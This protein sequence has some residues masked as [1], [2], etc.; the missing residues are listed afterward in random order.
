MT[1]AQAA[2][3]AAATSCVEG[4]TTAGIIED[5]VEYKTWLDEQDKKDMQPPPSATP[6]NSIM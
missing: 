2:L 5:A 6:W 1:N 4:A 3:F